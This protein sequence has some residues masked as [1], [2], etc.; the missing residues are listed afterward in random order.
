MCAS[1]A[2]PRRSSTCVGVA[3]CGTGEFAEAVDLT[4]RNAERLAQLVSHE[5]PLTEAPEAL[6]FA[7]E[8][9]HEVMKVVIRGG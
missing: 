6:H 8:H 5:F 2:S 7:M 3:C 9:P 1:A 4:E